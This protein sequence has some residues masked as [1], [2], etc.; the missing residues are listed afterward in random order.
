MPVVLKR[1][2]GAGKI[3]YRSLGHTADEFA[4]PEMARIVERGLLWAARG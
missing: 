2:Y 4:V 3:V 1:R